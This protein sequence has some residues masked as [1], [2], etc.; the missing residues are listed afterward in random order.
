MGNMIELKAA[1]GH[2]F[3]AYVAQPA[4]KAKGAVVVLQE[5]FRIFDFLVT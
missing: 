2:T 4:G 5:L 3:A 1:D